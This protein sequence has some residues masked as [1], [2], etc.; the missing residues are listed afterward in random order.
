MDISD[1]MTD[2]LPD[3]QTSKQTSDDTTPL[4]EESL[5]SQDTG[6]LESPSSGAQ[7]GSTDAPYAKTQQYG[8]D[9]GGGDTPS[10]FPIPVN[11]SQAS[12]LVLR[13]TV[14]ATPTFQRRSTAAIAPNRAQQTP[15]TLRPTT[16]SR[17]F[18]KFASQDYHVMRSSI[19]LFPLSFVSPRD[20]ARFYNRI[21]QT[22]E[23]RARIAT[24][25]S[26]VMFLVYWICTAVCLSLSIFPSSGSPVQV[27]YSICMFLVLL[28]SIVPYIAS[29]ASSFRNHI[30]TLLYISVLL[31][32]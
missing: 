7:M 13:N 15:S 20:E 22:F 2:T 4:V 17:I 28:S 6:N 27:M 23:I 12:N 31:V 32:S 26:L 11:S 21:V 3:A 16:G 19:I 10:S 18:G 24:I 30:E 9:D 1:S 25:A 29:A 8:P 14:P 5:A